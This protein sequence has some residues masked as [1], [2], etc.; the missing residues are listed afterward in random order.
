MRFCE[1]WDALGVALRQLG[2]ALEEFLKLRRLCDILESWL[3][4]WR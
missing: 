1:A 3:G 4:R 2:E